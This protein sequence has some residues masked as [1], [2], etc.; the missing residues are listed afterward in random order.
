MFKQV[1]CAVAVLM[2]L[3]ACGKEERSGSSL[4]GWYTDLSSVARTDSF[5]RINQAIANHECIYTTGYSHAYDYYATPELFFYYNGMWRSSDSHYGT[6]RFLPSPGVQIT[7]INIVND[8]TMVLYYA[9]LW[10]PDTL[11][12]NAG[13]V[14]KVYAGPYFGELVYY[15]DSPSY[16]SYVLVDNKLVVSN[17]D[18]YTI[19]SNGLIK[20]GT[21]KLLS[22]YDPSRSF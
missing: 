7:V 9:D 6:C 16:Y 20:D 5:N 13:I 10:D 18:I 3:S 12:G 17:G 21:S 1:A 2:L 19:T 14:G 8:N 15:D 11:S 4:N 22:K